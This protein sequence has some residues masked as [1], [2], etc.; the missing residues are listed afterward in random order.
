V[1]EGGETNFPQLNIA[2]KPKKGAAVLWANVQVREGRLESLTRSRS[3]RRMRM[4]FPLPAS[5]S[6]QN[7]DPD[8][9]AVKSQHAALPVKAGLKIAANMWLYQVG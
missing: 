9:L 4:R 1:D 6:L 5:S 2:V 7:E 3:P 8:Q